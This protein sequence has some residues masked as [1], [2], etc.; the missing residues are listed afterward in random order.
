M[1]KFDAADFV[2]RMIA[3][4]NNPKNQEFLREAERHMN[5]YVPPPE[6]PEAACEPLSFLKRVDEF[7]VF[8]RYTSYSPDW[9]GDAVA[10]TRTGTQN[11][12]TTVE[13]D[14][15]GQISSLEEE[16][17][18]EE[19]MNLISECQQL[20]FLRQPDCLEGG[21]T[22]HMEDDWFGLR[23]AE[24]TAKWMQIPGCVSR[25]RIEID[26]KDLV[27]KYAPAFFPRLINDEADLD[28]SEV[29]ESDP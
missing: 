9:P 8:A 27:R 4:K 3:S 13:W 5:N 19:F 22:Y 11:L 12:R 23:L 2:K 1:E 25:E 16:I 7:F 26:L 24:S 18:A 28:E 20:D 17:P 14:E 21:V 10:F 29:V 6:T 15:N